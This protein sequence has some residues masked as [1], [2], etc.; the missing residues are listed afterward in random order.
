VQVT[1]EVTGLDGGTLRLLSKPDIGEYHYP[2][3]RGP[4]ATQDGTWDVLDREVGEDRGKGT[5][6]THVA[7]QADAGCSSTL[8]PGRSRRSPRGLPRPRA[9]DDSCSPVGTVP[10]PTTAD[11]ATAAAPTSAPCGVTPS[12]SACCCS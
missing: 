2:T 7:V 4:L 10:G 1:V 11:P 5:G 9:P 8:A 6:I 12:A 3:R